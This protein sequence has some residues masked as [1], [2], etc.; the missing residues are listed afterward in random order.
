MLVSFRAGKGAGGQS[1]SG[2]VREKGKE[3]HMEEWKGLREG[4][5]GRRE[6]GERRGG[7]AGLRDR[8][9]DEEKDAD[10][11]V[12]EHGSKDEDEDGDGDGNQKEYGDEGGGEDKDESEGEYEHEF[13]DEDEDGHKDIDK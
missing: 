7:R 10:E 9:G 5:R 11:D 2:R 1:A 3:E 8:D 6:K 13:T 12:D 4:E